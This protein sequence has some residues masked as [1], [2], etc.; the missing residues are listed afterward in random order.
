MSQEST[1]SRKFELVN[2]SNAVFTVK[3]TVCE[4]F[5]FALVRTFEN[6]DPSITPAE[7]TAKN[8]SDHVRLGTKPYHN[9]K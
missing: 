8:V 3:T 5:E 7:T 9:R 6:R 2:S 4:Q 1:V